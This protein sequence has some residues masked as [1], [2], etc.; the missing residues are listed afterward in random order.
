MQ[1]QHSLSINNPSQKGG[2]RTKNGQTLPV[3]FV[4]SSRVRVSPDPI[5]LDSK[6][7]R[8]RNDCNIKQHLQPMNLMSDTP[9]RQN[10]EN[11]RNWDSG[12]RQ[13]GLDIRKLDVQ[14]Q[15]LHTKADKEEEIEFQKARENFI[16]KVVSVD[17]AVCA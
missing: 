5:Q 10:D 15:Q 1:A 12:Q 14:N 16:V 4:D 17:F 7:P 2:K 6:I 8:S 3:V 13:P 11:D 9:H